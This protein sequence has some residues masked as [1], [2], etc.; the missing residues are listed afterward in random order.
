[1]RNIYV[2]YTETCGENDIVFDDR[3]HCLGAWS[4]NDATWR[5]EYFAPFLEKLG[6]KVLETLPPHINADQLIA[7]ALKTEMGLV[8]E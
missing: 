1:M 5:N 2:I 8:D 7:E 6:I 3:F 4:C